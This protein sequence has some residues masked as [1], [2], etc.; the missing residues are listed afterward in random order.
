MVIASYGQSW[1]HQV[2]PLQLSGFTTATWA[3]RFFSGEIHGMKTSSAVT[4]PSSSHTMPGPQVSRS[5]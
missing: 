2:Q 1:K 4:V 5:G 3:R